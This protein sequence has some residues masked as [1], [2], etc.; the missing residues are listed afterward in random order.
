MH[1]CSWEEPQKVKLLENFCAL[2]TSRCVFCKK[3]C[4]GGNRCVFYFVGFILA[5]GSDY[6]ILK[7]SQSLLEQN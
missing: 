3:Y 4:E 6:V 2:K 5:T 1:V 7:S